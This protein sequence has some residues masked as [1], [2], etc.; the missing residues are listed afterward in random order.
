MSEIVSAMIRR[1]VK[2]SKAQKNKKHSNNMKKLNE[3]EED[4]RLV[5]CGIIG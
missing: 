5:V 3:R 4:M 1:K 2:S